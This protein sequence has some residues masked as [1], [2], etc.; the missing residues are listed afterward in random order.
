MHIRLLLAVT[1]LLAIGCENKKD[2]RAVSDNGSI[3]SDSLAANITVLASDSF[4]GRKPFTEG[5]I[6]TIRYLE[7]KFREV[8]LEPG[9]GSSYLQD[10]PMVRIRTAAA[11]IMKVHSPKGDFNLKGPDDYVVWTDK[12]DS[13]LSLDNAEVVF[14]GYGVVAPEYNW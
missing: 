3:S 10:V 8:G 6:K 2:T 12:T 1:I 13:L 7:D 14:A 4:M 9:N 11:P 5:E